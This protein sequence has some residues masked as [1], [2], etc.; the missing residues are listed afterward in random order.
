MMLIQRKLECVTNPPEAF[1]NDPK[2]RTFDVVLRL[3]APEHLNDEVPVAASS[4]A[5]ASGLWPWVAART[6]LS[7]QPVVQKIARYVCSC[8]VA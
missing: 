8:Y 3:T 2:S 7:P 5:M 1:Y 6:R 4:I